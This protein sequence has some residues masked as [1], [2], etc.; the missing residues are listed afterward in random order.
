MSALSQGRA[1]NFLNAEYGGGATPTA[2]VARTGQTKLVITTAVGTQSARGTQLAAGGGYVAGGSN[3]LWN[4]AAVATS[5][6]SGTIGNQAWE[7]TN[8]PASA[9]LNGVEITD[10]NA[11]PVYL[12]YGA[13]TGAPKSTN[14]GDT[15]SFPANSLVVSI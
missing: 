6:Y 2:F 7:Q 10:S 11:T 8:M 1:T 5:T 15:L 13:I 9:A 4:A 14:A 12:A 3:V